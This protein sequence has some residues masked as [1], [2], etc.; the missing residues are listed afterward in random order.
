MVPEF[1]SQ[2]FLA[3]KSFHYLIKQIQIITPLDSKLQI[4]FETI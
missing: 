4:L 3:C 2:F 1:R